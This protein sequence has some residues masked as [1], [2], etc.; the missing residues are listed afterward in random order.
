MTSIDHC[1]CQLVFH[2]LQ[3]LAQLN[4]ELVAKDRELLASADKLEAWLDLRDDELEARLV[5]M[6]EMEAQ[7]VAKDEELARVVAAND[8]ELQQLRAQLERLEGVPPQRADP[9]P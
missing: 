4:R 7:L 8:E 3:V 1:S 9:E 5:E 2:D 6:D